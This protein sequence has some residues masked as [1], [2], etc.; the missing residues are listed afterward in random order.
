MALPIPD[1]GRAG[2]AAG[3]APGSE[4]LARWGIK[5]ANY[6]PRLREVGPYCSGD[7]VVRGVSLTLHANQCITTLLTRTST[8]GFGI[9]PT[10][11]NTK[12]PQP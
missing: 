12:R 3:L 1:G 9:S 2:Q 10:S 11:G 7:G 6:T 5:P 8:R 4:P